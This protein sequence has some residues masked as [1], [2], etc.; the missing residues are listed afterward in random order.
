[1]APPVAAPAA[2]AALPLPNPVTSTLARSD[3][4]QASAAVQRTVALLKEH[5]LNGFTL[6]LATLPPGSDLTGY[7]NSIDRRIDFSSIYIHNQN[8]KGKPYSVVYFGRYAN[9]DEAEAA[10]NN[11]PEP[12][13][14]NQPHIRTWAKI[15][16]ETSP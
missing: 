14:A 2:P 6:Q 4:T 3:S 5:N 16:Q 10:L 11:L 7:M 13:K 9:R 1:M 8:R 15:R 12:L